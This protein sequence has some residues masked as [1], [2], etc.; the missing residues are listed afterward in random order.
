MAVEK[1]HAWALRCK[2]ATQSQDQA[3]FGIVQGGVFQDLRQA[4]AEYISSLDLP[5]NAIGG[6]SVGETKAEMHAML[7]VV[8]PILPE[9]RPRYL[10]GVGSPEDLV[11]GVMRG[12]DIFD[13]V[14]P[15]RLA[16]HNTAITRSRRLNLLNAAFTR[17][18]YPID[19]D[20]RCYTCRRFTRAYLRHLLIAK[21]MLAPSLISIHNLYTLIHLVKDIRSSILDGRFE[22]FTQ[23]F[24][25]SRE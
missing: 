10:M 5:G 2:E 7:D 17:D 9:G 4:S 20:C 8:D 15:T 11:N 16:R 25:Q 6:L 13:S 24:F 18:E 12:I 3:L 21:E 22:N 14:L 1:T 23:N 19:T